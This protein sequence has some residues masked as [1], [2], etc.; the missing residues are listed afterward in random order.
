[1][2]ERSGQAKK[3]TGQDRTGN[4]VFGVGG[5]IGRHGFDDVGGLVEMGMDGW[6]DGWI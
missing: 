6:M 4:G 3:K 2:W 1:M 5:F